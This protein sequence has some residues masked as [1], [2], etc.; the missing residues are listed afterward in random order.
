MRFPGPQPYALIFSPPGEPVPY[1]AGGPQARGP[2]TRAE[3]LFRAIDSELSDAALALAFFKRS[4]VDAMVH[5]LRSA[6]Q[7]ARMHAR[8]F[9]SSS[10]MTL[11]LLGQIEKIGKGCELA[12]VAKNAVAQLEEEVPDLK[13]LRNSIQHV[14]ERLQ[15]LAWGKPIDPEP[16]DTADYKGPQVHVGILEGE[17]FRYTAQDGT[18]AE[19]RISDATLVSVVRW[20]QWALNNAPWYTPWGGPPGQLVRFKAEE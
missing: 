9:V 17:L 10:E 8:S 12:D 6:H 11:K 16:L 18:Q 19:I 1:D 7:I 15:G 4:D 13:G 14:E 3:C 20:M 5:G 2:A